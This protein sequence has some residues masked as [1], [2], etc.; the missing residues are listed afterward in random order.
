M[1][2][3]WMWKCNFVLFELSYLLDSSKKQSQ[4]I[5]SVTLKTVWFVV[6]VKDSEECNE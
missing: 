6:V 2:S 5:K 4:E 3:I 1:K